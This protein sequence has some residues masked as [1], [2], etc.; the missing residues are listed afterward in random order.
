[1]T[2]APDVGEI[3]SAESR[4]NKV[5]VETVESNDKKRAAIIVIFIVVALSCECVKLLKYMKE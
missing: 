1:V 3:M 5:E 4:F 2:I